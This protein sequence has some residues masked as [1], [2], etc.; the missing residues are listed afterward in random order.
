VWPSELVSFATCAAENNLSQAK[1]SKTGDRELSGE[2]IQERI[3]VELVDH[4]FK[5]S[6]PSLEQLMVQYQQADAGATAALIARLSPQ[7][8]RFFATQMGSRNDA[9]D[10][11]QDLW[12]R[13]HR[14]RHTYRAGEP[15]L[16]WAYA[17]AHRVRIDSYRR[18]R[19]VSREI[20]V[21]V[22]PEPPIPHERENDVPAFEELIATLSEGQREV[23]TMLK[24]D[25]LT[26]EEIA[27]ATCS[28]VGAV[29]QKA[30][31]AYEQLRRFLE[32]TPAVRP[33]RKGVAR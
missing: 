12:L 33:A 11:L 32:E 10:M 26:V 23:I 3:A 7:L 30:H 18:R 24:V 19:R 16:P 2:Y 31:R 25:G 15:L 5:P 22:L 29:K 20:G 6:E 9:G 21:K 4:A 8:Y 1:L 17:I 13:I 27:R 28:T 14:V